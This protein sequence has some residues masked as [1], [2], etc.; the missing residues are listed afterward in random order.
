[1]NPL[2]NEEPNAAK[3]RLKTKKKLIRFLSFVDECTPYEFAKWVADNFLSNSGE[4]TVIGVLAE[5]LHKEEL[6]KE[7]DNYDGQFSVLFHQVLGKFGIE[8]P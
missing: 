2:C 6:S 8:Y 3:E 4:E 7:L 5:I 1:M